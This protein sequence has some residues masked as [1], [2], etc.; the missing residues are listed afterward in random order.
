MYE[1]Q[2]VEAVAPA[3]C[4]ARRT[5]SELHAALFLKSCTELPRPTGSPAIGA[6]MLYKTTIDRKI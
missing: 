4:K 2:K 5:L 6:T 3:F 1:E